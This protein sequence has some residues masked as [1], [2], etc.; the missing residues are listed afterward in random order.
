[1]VAKTKVT[2]MTVVRS[3]KGCQNFGPGGGRGGWNELLEVSFQS[4]CGGNYLRKCDPLS[5]HQVAKN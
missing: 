2:G 3:G 4:Q 1:M 5:L